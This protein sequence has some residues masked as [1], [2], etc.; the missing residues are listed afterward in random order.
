[1]ITDAFFTLLAVRSCRHLPPRTVIKDT[2][3]HRRIRY[4]RW[5]TVRRGAQWDGSGVFFESRTSRRLVPYFG[6]LL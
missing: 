1:M 6:A 5:P 3:H 4:A 2:E